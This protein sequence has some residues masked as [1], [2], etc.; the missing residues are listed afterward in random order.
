MS[1]MPARTAAF[2]L[3]LMLTL[4]GPAGATERRTDG[5]RS[6]DAAAS[7]EL[8]A[9]RY[10]RGRYWGVRRAYW[11]PRYGF[12]RPYYPYYARYYGYP[13]SAGYPYYYSRPVFSIGFGF[14]PRWGWGWW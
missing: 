9:Q 10:W 14:G 1:K 2:A 13:Y 5:L 7:T 8:S 11:G 6:Q 12:Y 3:T 4:P